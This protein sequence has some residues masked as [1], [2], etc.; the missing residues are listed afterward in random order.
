MWR[1][2]PFITLK[3]RTKYKNAGNEVFF[4]VTPP[5]KTS[6]YLFLIC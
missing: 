2:S 4:G 5:E 6:F 1:E 3:S